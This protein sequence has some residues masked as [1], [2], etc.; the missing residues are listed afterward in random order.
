MADEM[1]P[2]DP[3][4]LDQAIEQARHELDAI[5][6]SASVADHTESDTDDVTVHEV[7]GAGRYAVPH[8]PGWEALLSIV[9]DPDIAIGF[10]IESYPVFDRV[11]DGHF[12]GMQPPDVV[13]EHYRRHAYLRENIAAVR[14]F[15]METYY[16]HTPEGMTPEK[17][18]SSQEQIAAFVGEGLHNDLQPAGFIPQLGDSG[19]T[20]RT[21][22]ACR[23]SHEKNRS[24]IQ[25]LQAR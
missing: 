11:V 8:R 12:Q 4:A 15:L 18:L 25:T 9:R 1:T 21:S 17:A 16:S 3:A 14:N 23:R 19:Y 13:G 6:A 7:D 10:S 5:V 24:H 22:R 20:T 2:D